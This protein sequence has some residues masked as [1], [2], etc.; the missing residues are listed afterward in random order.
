[1]NT[2]T[3]APNPQGNV[4]HQVEV[5]NENLPE[6]LRDLI[7]ETV[8]AGAVK[9][10]LDAHPERTYQAEL[11]KTAEE[12]KAENVAKVRAELASRL[13]RLAEP[14]TFMVG[15]IVRWKAGLQNRNYPEHESLFIVAEILDEPVVVKTHEDSP[16]ARERLDVRVLALAEGRPESHAAFEWHVD[17]RRIEK[18]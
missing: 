14:R 17:G 8:K 16:Y 5:L 15:D 7:E 9:R 13:A 2:E 3:N 4:D 12:Q 6:S 10:E 1:M 11:D 18:A